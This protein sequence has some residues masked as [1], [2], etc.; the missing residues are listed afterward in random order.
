[1][2]L[3]G[4]FPSEKRYSRQGCEDETNYPKIMFVIIFVTVQKQSFIKF[5]SINMMIV[6]K[7]PKSIQNTWT[8]RT[9]LILRRSILAEGEGVQNHTIQILFQSHSTSDRKLWSTSLSP[10]AQTITK[11]HCEV[12]ATNHK[13]E[14]SAN[15]G[16]RSV[17]VECI[18]CQ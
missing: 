12:A 17:R 8:Y 2:N 10:W 9:I 11:E 13:E 3:F 6:S 4:V 15:E 14:G 1:M 7:E 16:L 18:W 5:H